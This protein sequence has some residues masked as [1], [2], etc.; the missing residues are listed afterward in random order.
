[1]APPSATAGSTA[2]FAALFDRP[3]LPTIKTARPTGAG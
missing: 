2:V 3:S 1:M